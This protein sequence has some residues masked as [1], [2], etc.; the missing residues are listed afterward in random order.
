MIYDKQFKFVDDNIELINNSLN[1]LK[2]RFKFHVSENNLLQAQNIERI[3]DCIETE[4][5]NQKMYVYDW[6][7]KND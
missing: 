3:I 4:L 7:D 5:L 6:S 2:K 1:F